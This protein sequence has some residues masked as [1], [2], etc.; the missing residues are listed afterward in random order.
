PAGLMLQWAAFRLVRGRGPARAFWAGFLAGGLLAAWSLVGAMLFRTSVNVGI[1]R[2]TGAVHR[3]VTPGWRAA[4]YSWVAW[5]GYV[6]FVVRCLGPLPSTV[7]I[8]DRGE[9]LGAVVGVVVALVPQLG[10]ALAVGL[11]ARLLAGA[12]WP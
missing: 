2:M 3:I 1:N 5:E 8:A 6:E 10:L 11:L 9:A 12:R 7:G 4:D